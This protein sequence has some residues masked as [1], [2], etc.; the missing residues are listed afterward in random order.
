VWPGEFNLLCRP[1][2]RIKTC[3]HG[4][5]VLRGMMRPSLLE[6]CN[7]IVQSPIQIASNNSLKTASVEW[8][9]HL[10]RLFGLG[11]PSELGLLINWRSEE[12]RVGIECRI[13]TPKI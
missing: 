12:R 3:P 8:T 9:K 11:P 13:G 1:S 4:L 6:L 10:G 5:L 2:S 7:V